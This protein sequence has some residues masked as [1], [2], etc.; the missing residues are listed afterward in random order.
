MRTTTQQDRQLAACGREPP[1]ANP[2]LLPMVQAWSPQ[3]YSGPPPAT[4]PGYTCNL[5][6][7]IEIARARLHWSKGALDTFVGDP[8]PDEMLLGIEVLEGAQNEADAWAMANPVKKA[9][10]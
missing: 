4:C 6:E 9:G 5:P 8:V 2:R 3:S 10:A 1:P 7:V